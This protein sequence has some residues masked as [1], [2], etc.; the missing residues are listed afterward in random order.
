MRSARRAAAL[1]AFAVAALLVVGCGVAS[2]RTALERAASADHP[3]RFA[4]VDRPDAASL[5]ECLGAAETLVVTVD[6]ERNAMAVR[7]QDETNPVV[8]WTADAS[9][10]DA[11]LLTSGVGWVRVGRDLAGPTRAEVEAAV[12]SSLSG[13]VFAERIA[14]D[15]MTV[16]RSALAVAS[17]ISETVSS[18][19]DVT[20]SVEVD[21]SVG[22]VKGLDVGPIPDLQFTVV[23]GRIASIG[24]RLPS[25]GEDSFGFVWEYDPRTDVAGVEPP[26]DATDVAAIASTIGTGNRGEIGCALGL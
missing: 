25:D 15:P 21:E 19:G 23:D 13:W 4:F 14:P 26:L 12:G 24:A 18:S 10:V 7:R 5:M 22:D 1:S 8:V 17:D 6:T 11:S 16:A 9:F 3:A 2:G 20:V